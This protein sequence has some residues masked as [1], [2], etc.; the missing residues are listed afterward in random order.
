VVHGIAACIAAIV[1]ASNACISP[2]LVVG[3]AL[4]VGN[5]QIFNFRKTK[6][7]FDNVKEAGRPF[8]PRLPVATGA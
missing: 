7:I 5:Q 3:D 6:S 1:P 2:Q 8:S 4:S